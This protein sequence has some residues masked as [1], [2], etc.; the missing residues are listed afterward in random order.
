VTFASDY[1]RHLNCT[2]RSI[3]KWLLK[4]Q[5]KHPQPLIQRYSTLSCSYELLNHLSEWLQN[6]FVSVKSTILCVF[7]P[8]I[9]YYWWLMMWGLVC[10]LSQICWAWIAF[11]VL[12]YALFSLQ[13]KMFFKLVFL[14]CIY[15]YNW[16]ICPRVLSSVDSLLLFEQFWHFIVYI[17][18]SYGICG[19]PYP[20]S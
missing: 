19:L 6:S 15:C 1:L 2:R 3:G 7:Y 11:F 17:L 20:G 12:F 13:V 9:Y 14:L 4:R 8:F 18:I 5:H 16:K 10:S